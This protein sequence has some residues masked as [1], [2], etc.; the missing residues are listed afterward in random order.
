MALSCVGPAQQVKA[1]RAGLNTEFDE[2][3]EVGDYLKLFA[4]KAKYNYA[5]IRLAPDLLHCIYVCRMQ[6]LLL[7]DSDAALWKELKHERYRT[8]LLRSWMPFL[9]TELEMAGCLQRC[10][11]IGCNVWLL[12]ATTAQLDEIVVEGVK[13]GHLKIEACA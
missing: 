1:L 6:G 10:D 8:P 9:R 13:R 2:P 7:N 12:S 11:S 5:A 3:F 4:D